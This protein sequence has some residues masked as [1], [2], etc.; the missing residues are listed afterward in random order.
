MATYIGKL[1]NIWVGAEWTRG[2]G[3]SSFDYIPKLSFS[4]DTKIE[5]EDNEAGIWKLAK[6]TDTCVSKI[7]WEWE[8]EGHLWVNIIW[9]FIKNMLW[10]VSSVETAD[11]SWAYKHTF[12]L[13]HNNLHPSLAISIVEPN[14]NEVFP[15]VMCES[16][17]ISW[18]P[19]K[20]LNFKSSFKSKNAT[21]ASNTATYN[22]DYNLN[23]NN[24][25]VKIADNE[26]GLSSGTNLDL[27][28]FEFKVGTDLEDVV[29]IWS[30]EVKE[31]FNKLVE[32]SGSF[33]L[34]YDTNDYKNLYL[35]QT[36]K[37]IWIYIEDT[38]TVIGSN[39]DHPK[40]N[41]VLPRVN[42]EEWA[43]N[44]DEESIVQQTIWFKALY[45]VENDKLVDVE[46]VNTK[47]S[48]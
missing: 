43:R 20:C 44:V 21:S 23:A 9:Y 41:I 47:A 22:K 32:V 4:F 26:A 12:A 16:L 2:Q 15:L 28:N 7:S 33:E 1:I 24:I 10:D 39:S 40:L 36:K 14:Q 17:E 8:V 18:E 29:E 46:L 6:S 48:Y 25:S 11:N 3:A 34:L 35:N 42:L 13:A 45:D 5:V 27:L 30:N 19:W 31:I 38:G 37:A